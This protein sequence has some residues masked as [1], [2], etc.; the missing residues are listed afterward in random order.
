[1]GCVEMGKK[2]SWK[3]KNKTINKSIEKKN[4]ISL[5]VLR[6]DTS[7]KVCLECLSMKQ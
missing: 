2:G 5:L 1:M 6:G 4:E 7:N 3:K